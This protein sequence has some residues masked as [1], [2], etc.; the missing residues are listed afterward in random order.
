MYTIRKMT[1]DFCS[2][3][4]NN[5]AFI[6]KNNKE[7]VKI[8]YEHLLSDVKKLA[9]GIVAKNLTDTR[10]VVSGKNSYLWFVSALAVFYSGNVLVPIDGGLSEEEFTRVID[11]SGASL[12]IYSKEITEK[13]SKQNTAI[14]VCMDDIES[15]MS[16]DEKDMPERNPD[17]LGVLMFTSGT[18]SDSKAVMLSQNNI[19]SNV[20]AL[21]KWERFT[22]E[23][24]NLALLPFFHAFG[25]TATLLFLNVGMCSVFCEGLRVKKAL[26]DYDI[27][28]FVGVPLILDK[29]KGTVETVLRKKKILG[30]FNAMRS[31]SRFCLKF[32]L[33]LRGPL[34]KVVR[35]NLSKLRLIISGAAAL[36]PETSNF[37]NDIGILL[38]QGYGLTETAPVLSAENEDNIRLGSVGKALPGIEVKIDSP[39]ADGYGEIIAK[40]PNV[41]LGYMGEDVSPI[42]DGY[43][44]TGD[45]GYIDKDGF[46]FINGRK[47]NVIV[48]PNGKNVF[49]EETELLYSGIDGVKES[50]VYLNEEGSRPFISAKIVYDPDITNPEILAEETKKINAQLPH[51]KEV[52]KIEY[53][54]EEFKKTSTGKIKRNTL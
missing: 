28:I 1:D 31:F 2:K 54:T 52:K 18:T 53:T 42:K 5:T 30:V 47:K 26:T 23:D 4:K 10:I 19:I 50:V 32:G 43:F 44:H 51:F 46:I 35:S 7:Q 11:R 16:T 21:N 39:D 40:G 6:V 12:I 14:K 37:F 24:V 34:F 25:L 41:M 3:F 45:I 48:L 29:M 27:T 49:P 17:D 15:L 13:A 22:G 33:D 36:S 8:T 38:I 9:N 20:V